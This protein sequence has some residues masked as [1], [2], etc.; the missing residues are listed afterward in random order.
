MHGEQHLLSID[1]RGRGPAVAS[2]LLQRGYLI[3][4][5]TDD[6]VRLSLGCWNTPDEIDGCIDTLLEL[7]PTDAS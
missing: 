4:F 5:L 7:E 3:R 6:R 2:A 1:V